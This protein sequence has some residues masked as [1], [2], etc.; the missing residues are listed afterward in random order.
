MPKLAWLDMVE[1]G[2]EQASGPRGPA[3]SNHVPRILYFNGGSFLRAKGGPGSRA[4]DILWPPFRCVSSSLS[5]FCSVLSNRAAAPPSVLPHVPHHV[6]AFLGTQY[7]PLVEA[8]SFLNLFTVVL[9]EW[10]P[11]KEQIPGAQCSQERYKY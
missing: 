10:H 9:K 8:D 3:F 4:E 5:F 1:A 2:A 11:D 7:R 6:L